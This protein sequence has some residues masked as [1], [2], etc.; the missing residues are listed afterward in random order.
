MEVGQE[1]WW[2]MGTTRGQAEAA[3][4][5]VVHVVAQEMIDTEAYPVEFLL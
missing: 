5:A 4:S 3:C 2:Y 1:R